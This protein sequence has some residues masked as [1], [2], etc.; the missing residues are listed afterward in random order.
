MIHKLD[1]WKYFRKSP[2]CVNFTLD[3]GKWDILLILKFD[4]L[5]IGKWDI[6]LILKFDVW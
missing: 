1:V 3:I 6:L 5:D 4:T 2:T